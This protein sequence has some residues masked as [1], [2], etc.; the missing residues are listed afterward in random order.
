M[1]HRHRRRTILK[2][3]AGAPLLAFDSTWAA[4]P[5]RIAG[6]IEQAKTQA[7]ISQRIDT[8]SR[9]LL[10]TRYQAR[11]LI[12]SPNQKEVFVVR[13]DAFDCVTYNEFVLAAAMA[14]DVAEFEDALR[15]IRYHNGEVTWRERNHY[16]ADWSRHNVE[17]GIC[18]PVDLGGTVKLEKSSDS[19]R[20]LGRR[21]W[22]LD[23][24]PQAVM[25]ANAAKLL[26]GDIVGFVSRRSNLDYFHTGFVAFGARGELLLRHAS[27]TRRRVIDE[28]MASFIAV[29]GPKYVS[30]LRP[31]EPRRS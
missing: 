6:L 12:G 28:R 11:T 26:P 15:R 27:S 23:V 29:N 4:G 17:N 13:E 20:G 5:R 21:S 7:A 31:Q 3:L 22:T 2:L 18:R 10:G 25:L 1:Q 19:E 14:R 8:I 16:Y 9:V 30:V 24:T